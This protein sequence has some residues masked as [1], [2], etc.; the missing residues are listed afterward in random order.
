MPLTLFSIDQNDTV[1]ELKAED[2]VVND[3]SFQLEVLKDSIENLQ[4]DNADLTKENADPRRCTSLVQEID[5]LKGEVD[6]LVTEKMHKSHEIARL[7]LR[8]G[9]QG[10]VI[11]KYWKGIFP[12]GAPTQHVGHGSFLNGRQVFWRK[13]S[14]CIWDED[15]HAP[16]FGHADPGCNFVLLHRC[17]PDR[18]TGEDTLVH[19]V[20]C[21]VKKGNNIKFKINDEEACFGF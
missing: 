13:G 5:R 19:A 8:V 20:G 6:T 1:N 15:L 4:K 12:H 17:D 2:V 14:Q 11:S 7:K 18:N 16:L 21:H 10:R 3:T 9:G